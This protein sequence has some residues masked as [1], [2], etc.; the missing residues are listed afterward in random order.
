MFVIPKAVRMWM[1]K[2]HRDFLHPVKWTK[3]YKDKSNRD[4]G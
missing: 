4:L 1:K 2:I 3:A